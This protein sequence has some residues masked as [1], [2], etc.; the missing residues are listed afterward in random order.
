MP[1]NF[2]A[3][4]E[5]LLQFLY[6]TPWGLL[7]AS[8]SGDIQMLNP[9]AAKLLMPLAFN[10]RLDNLFDLLRGARPELQSLVSATT[11]RYCVVCEDLPMPAL[12]LQGASDRSVSISIFVQKQDTLMVILRES[13]LVERCASS[14]QM[15]ELQALQ[16]LPRVGLLKTRNGVI[17]WS[18]P[19]AQRLLACSAK[20]LQDAPF[21]ELFAPGVGEDLLEASLP[22]LMAGASYTRSL[23]LLPRPG[24][25]P[26]LEFC[27]TSTSF[28]QNEILWTLL[29]APAE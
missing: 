22:T 10:G 21:T 19:A 24:A 28:A 17:H 9:V 6:R 23:P 26:V 2:E 29:D 20:Q 8:R 11:E 4:Y 12:E 25:K 5:E 16:N 14:S 27:A 13:Q 15:A 1:Q 18:N 3:M 7:Q